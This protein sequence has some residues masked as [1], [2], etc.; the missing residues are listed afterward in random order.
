MPG[1]AFSPG[2]EGEGLLK[3]LPDLGHLPGTDLSEKTSVSNLD[4]TSGAIT[5]SRSVSPTTVLE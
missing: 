1:G 5:S 3:R 2:P 4:W